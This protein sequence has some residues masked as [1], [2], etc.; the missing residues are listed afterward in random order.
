MLCTLIT[1]QS[2]L[3]KMWQIRC[4]TFILRERTTKPILFQYRTASLC[5][6]GHLLCTDT[7]SCRMLHALQHHLKPVCEFRPQ[8]HETQRAAYAILIA[9]QEQQPLRD[10]KPCCTFKRGEADG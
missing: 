6:M 1:G 10:W 2:L 4:D 8:M 9:L 3:C 7:H 5:L